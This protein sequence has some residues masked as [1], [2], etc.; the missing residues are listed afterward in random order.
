MKCHAEEMM[1]EIG[2]EEC[3]KVENGTFYVMVYISK[4]THILL[5][6]IG[7]W[8]LVTFTPSPQ[9]SPLVNQVLKSY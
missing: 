4:P 2:I 1:N 3:N 5:I 7:S 8:H 9:T 6:Q